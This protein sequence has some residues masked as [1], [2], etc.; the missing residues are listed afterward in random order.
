MGTTFHIFILLLSLGSLPWMEGRPQEHTAAWGV[1]EVLDGTGNVM[2]G[3]GEFF[4]KIRKMWDSDKATESRILPHT[5]YDEIFRHQLDLDGVDAYLEQKTLD[6]L[7]QQ[8][9]LHKENYSRL[10]ILE[11]IQIPSTIIIS[12]TLLLLIFRKTYTLCKNQPTHA[13]ELTES[14]TRYAD[15]PEHTTS[16]IA[17]HELAPPPPPIPSMFPLTQTKLFSLSSPT[18]F[19]SA[20]ADSHSLNVPTTPITEHKRKR[21]I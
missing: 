20:V 17:N 3:L 15:P 14:P 21:A 19:R 13:P 10:A 18:P 5:P 4:H 2:E 12:I 11:I 1:Q 8:T 9:A 16:Y 7:L 6:A